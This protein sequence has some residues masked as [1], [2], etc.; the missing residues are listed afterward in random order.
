ME[1]PQTEKR[2]LV[3]LFLLWFDLDYKIIYKAFMTVGKCSAR[4]LWGW[5]LWNCF[6]SQWKKTNWQL[7]KRKERDSWEMVWSMHKGKNR[8]ALRCQL[9]C[10]S[11]LMLKLIWVQ[12]PDC[13]IWTIDLTSPPETYIYAFRG[14]RPL[15]GMGPLSKFTWKIWI[16]FQNPRENPKFALRPDP[17]FASNPL[18]GRSPGSNRGSFIPQMLHSLI[19]YF[20]KQMDIS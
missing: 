14:S 7:E 17:L 20:G 12:T 2:I 1:K 15:W 18:K 11:H 3:T 19:G 6:S 8:L 13:L 10:N 4:K 9:D 5:K 16:H